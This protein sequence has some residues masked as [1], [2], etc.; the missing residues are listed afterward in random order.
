PPQERDLL[1]YLVDAA[2]PFGREDRRVVDVL[3][4]TGAPVVLILNKVDL[5]KENGLLL[6]LIEQYKS[7]FEFA[8]FVPVSAAKGDGLAQ[9][10]QVIL[11]RLPEG[12]SYFPAAYI[13]DQPER[14]LAAELIR[15]KALQATRQQVPH[16]VAVAADKCG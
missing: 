8:D 5:V 3:R 10:K 11:E 6:P 16:A 13:T 2:L 12:P 14:F 15:A 9:L 1:P 4:R 7:S